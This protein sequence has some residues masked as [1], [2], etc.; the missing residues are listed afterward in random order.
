MTLRHLQIFVKVYENQSITKAGHQLH[1]AQPSISLAIKELEEHYHIQLFDRMNRRIF[2]TSSANKLYQYA[3]H[4]LSLYQKMEKDMQNYEEAGIIKIGS[5]MTISNDILPDIL[6][7]FKDKHSQIDVKIFV[8]NCENIEQLIIENKI[9]FALIENKPQ[10]EDI[11][12]IPFMSDYLSTIVAPHHPLLQKENIQLQELLAY[13][14][15]MREPGSSVY[16]L[17]NSV[18]ITHQIN[19]KPAMESTSTQAIIRAV[20]ANL[21]IATL[22][23]ML[24][25]Q[26][27]EE[28]KVKEIYVKQLHIK[29]DYNIIYHKNKYISDIALNFFK[30]CQNHPLTSL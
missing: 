4:I 10:N 24:V 6:K 3:K 29:R 22:P 15:L 16:N 23:Y 27:L 19:V 13:P 11:V 26:A 18:F 20:E 25:K 28:N 14:F 8:N 5:S 17:V 21:G 7:Q 30:T 12:H 2:P 9:D 1:I